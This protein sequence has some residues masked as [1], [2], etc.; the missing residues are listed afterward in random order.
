MT[1][2]AKELQIKKIITQLL[3]LCGILIAAYMLFVNQA[4][5]A[6]AAR[7]RAEANINELKGSVS[8]LEF[9]YIALRN[10]IT[11]DSARQLGFV[12]SSNEQFGKRSVSINR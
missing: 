6:T 3:I 4:I 7:Q 8:E 2:F 10:K 9:G 5:M 1:T 12:Q 11:P